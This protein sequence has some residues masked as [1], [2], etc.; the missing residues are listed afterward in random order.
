MKIIVYDPLYSSVGHFFRYNKYVLSLL[1][2]MSFI[3]EIVYVSNEGEGEIYK[4]ISS[5]V[6]SVQNVSDITSIQL[7]SIRTR[8]IK[9][10]LFYLRLMK[11]Y[12]RIV[13]FINDSECDLCLFTSNGILPFWLLSIVCLRKRFVVSAISI[14]WIYQG[15]SIVR[16]VLFAAYRKFLRCADQ[17]LVTE[18][19][20][21]QPLASHGVSNVSVL[22]DRYLQKQTPFVGSP[23]VSYD[24]LCMVTLGTVSS[25]K[26]PIEFIKILKNITARDVAFRYD[27]YGKSFDK[28]GSILKKIVAGDHR[29]RYFDQ[30][31]AN[32]EYVSLLEQADF[33]VIP[34]D[35]HYTRAMTSG[36]MWDCFEHR[37]PILCPDIEPFRFYVATYGIGFVFTDESLEN[38]IASILLN[39]SNVLKKIS[40]NY[41]TL[42]DDLSPK[43]MLEELMSAI[44]A[45]VS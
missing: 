19:C 11:S 6:V 4:A 22:H 31:V 23:Y 44:R 13:Q 40:L 15:T 38:L 9:Q 10:I 17:V 28:T 14:S 42:Y 36:V 7:E 12:W 8:G 30:Y 26:N 24:Q 33:V 18:H 20:Y 39:K 43:V 34:Y 29:I 1:A 3:S 5:K 25:G 32:R 35:I 21:I 2:D 16:Y 41:D 45:A 27:I 37:K